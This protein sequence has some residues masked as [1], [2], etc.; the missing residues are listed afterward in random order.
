MSSGSGDRYFS[1]GCPGLAAGTRR[2][3]TH[4]PV[5]C[6]RHTGR[7][8]P[9]RLS[10]QTRPDHINT[11]LAQF[12]L[13]LICGLKYQ[14][15]EPIF[16]GAFDGRFPGSS[17]Q[18]CGFLRVQPRLCNRAGQVIEVTFGVIDGEG[19]KLGVQREAVGG[20]LLNLGCGFVGGGDQASRSR[21]SR[22][23]VSSAW[24]IMLSAM[25]WA[26][27]RFQLSSRASFTVAPS[28]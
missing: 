20:G 22:S 14:G 17:Q 16:D 9:P 21:N 15:E 27:P 11:Q 2:R 6:H 26:T 28:P 23:L 5:L 7:P 4:A 8:S 18:G 3:C 13:S 24:V 1:S 25:V 12:L 19:V 10:E